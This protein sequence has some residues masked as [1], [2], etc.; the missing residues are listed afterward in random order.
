MGIS[1]KRKGYRGEKL[2]EEECH[3][4]GFDQ[5]HRIGQ[6]MY[7]VGSQVPDVAGL[8]GVHQEIKFVEKLNLRK[9]M[10]QSIQDAKAEGLNNV[11]IVAHKTSRQPW[12]VTM[13]GQDWLEMYRVWNMWR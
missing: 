13:L 7:Q 11:P 10:A 5:V 9:A 6:Q 2:W 3:K 8:D 1:Q 12:L 4:A